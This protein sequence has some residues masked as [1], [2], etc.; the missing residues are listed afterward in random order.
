MNPTCRSCGVALASTGDQPG[1]PACMLRMGLMGLAGPSEAL[2][3]GPRPGEQV[4]GWWL[5]E[6]LRRGPAATVFRAESPV[7]GR[8]VVL[9]FLASGLLQ[10]E[11]AYHRFVLESNRRLHHR[12]PPAS[13]GW[14]LLFA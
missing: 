2:L 13:N 9:K 6:V 4:D 7:D 3:G 8:P 1:C 5:V 12:Q 11:V 10:D 14:G